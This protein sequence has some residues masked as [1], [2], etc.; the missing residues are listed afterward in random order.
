MLAPRLRELIHEGRKRTVVHAATATA[1]GG[2]HAR[3][4]R[5]EF[6]CSELPVIGVRVSLN[7]PAVPGWNEI[8]AISAELC[9]PPEMTGKPIITDYITDP[10]EI[11]IE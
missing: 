9:D 10:F 8:D 1:A 4:N 5:V 6:G 11:E 3:I 7:S 2:P